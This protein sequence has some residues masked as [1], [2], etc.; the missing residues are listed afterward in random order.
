MLPLLS[1]TL[2]G[3]IKSL[4]VENSRH[5]LCVLFGFLFSRLVDS[6]NELRINE[7]KKNG[8][9]SGSGSV[10]MPKNAASLSRHVPY[11]LAQSAS[12]RLFSTPRGMPPVA[13]QMCT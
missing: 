12:P 4:L 7:R 2:R 10:L 13:T 1:H 5:F 6:L 8:S 3:R 9:C 11:R